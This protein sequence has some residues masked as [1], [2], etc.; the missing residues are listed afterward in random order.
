MS[1]DLNKIPSTYTEA[2]DLL[3]ARQGDDDDVAV[4]HM[5]DPAEKV[6]RLLEV[7]P[8]YKDEDVLGPV[9]M[10]ASR[11]FPYASHV[12]LVSEGDWQ[13][14]NCGEKPLPAG[15]DLTTLN[16]NRKG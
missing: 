16:K 9:S 10:G 7:S 14:V 8:W 1:V 15:C 3:A 12:I 13:R 6:V 11:D 2:V 5:P 4:Y